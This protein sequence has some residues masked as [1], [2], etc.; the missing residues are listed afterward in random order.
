MH[1][2]QIGKTLYEVFRDEHAPHLDAATCEAITHLKF[3][4]GEFDIEWGNSITWDTSEWH[5]EEIENFHE[6]LIRENM[7]PTDL[8]LSLGYLKIGQVNYNESFGTNNSNE[9]WRILGDHLDIYQIECN[10][11]SATYKYHWSDNDH[12]NLQLGALK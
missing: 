8:D 9:I 10:G 5:R 3:Y 2:C 1:W 7:S 11:V 12:E 6:W 4:S